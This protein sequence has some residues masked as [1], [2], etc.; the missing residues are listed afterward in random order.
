MVG[1]VVTMVDDSPRSGKVTFSIDG[2]GVL[3]IARQM[4]HEE[5]KIERALNIIKSGFGGITPEQI[6]AVLNGDAWIDSEC[7]YH[8]E[9]DAEYKLHLTEIVNYRTRNCTE[10]AERWVEN[11]DLAQYV[12][13]FCRP[14][15]ARIRDVRKRED[16]IQNIRYNAR[17]L[18]RYEVERIAFLEE[19]RDDALVRLVASAGFDGYEGDGYTMFIRTLDKFVDAFAGSLTREPDPIVDSILASPRQIRNKLNIMLACMYDNEDAYHNKLETMLYDGMSL[20]E[21]IAALLHWLT[22]E[23]V[24][25][26]QLHEWREYQENAD[27]LAETYK[28]KCELDEQRKQWDDEDKKQHQQIQHIRDAI[29]MRRQDLARSLTHYEL[30]DPEKIRVL[31]DGKD[32]LTRFARVIGRIAELQ[33]E[34]IRTGMPDNVYTSAICEV[35]RPVMD[36]FFCAIFQHPL[37]TETLQRELL[38]ELYNKRQTWGLNPDKDG[39]DPVLGMERLR[40]L[41]HGDE[42]TRHKLLLAFPITGDYERDRIIT[43]DFFDALNEGVDEATDVIA[44]AVNE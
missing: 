30:A 15:F 39:F 35:C 38:L 9:P 34:R 4:Y 24:G 40:G 22:D 14:L 43:I 23:N 6:T 37:P 33:L 1:S 2:K 41:I 10:I 19:M 20:E 7:Y 27:Y 29:H 42:G 8:D 25:A 26:E 18:S 12:V 16:G 3:K 31:G 17:D 13:G 28:V 5:Q 44:R 21:H 32:Y 11:R 36:D